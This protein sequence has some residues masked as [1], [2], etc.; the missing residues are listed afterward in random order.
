M[1]RC[2]IAITTASKQ[3]R[4]NVSNMSKVLKPKYLQ[5]IA[6][7]VV[8]AALIAQAVNKSTWTIGRWVKSNSYNLTLPGVVEIIRKH[9]GLS[10]D[11]ELLEDKNKSKAAA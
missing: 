6:N 8:L 5:R 11:V 7:D 2:N 4:I 9:E 1:K 3:Q 10:E